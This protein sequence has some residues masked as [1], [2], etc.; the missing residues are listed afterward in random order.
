M[1]VGLG[2]IENG[3]H[4][5]GGITSIFPEAHATARKN[6]GG[7]NAAGDRVQTTEQMDEQVTSDASAVVAI[8]APAKE[9]DRVEGMFGSMAEKAVPV[10]V[11]RI[12]VGGQGILPGT[13]GAVA[14]S[15]AS[16]RFNS[17]MVP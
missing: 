12:G 15:Q 14:I 4:D 7:P 2:V 3:E 8:I 5:I 13:Q 11:L 17:P 6:L 9:A 16:T 1:G 10:D